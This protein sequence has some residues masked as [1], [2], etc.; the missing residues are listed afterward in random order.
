MARQRR[1]GVAGGGRHSAVGALGAPTSLRCSETRPADNSLHSLRSL[2]SD[3]IRE[4]V[5]EAR[6]YAR[7]RASCAARRLITAA[8]GH[9]HAP[10]LHCRWWSKGTPRAVVE[11]QAV[12]GAIAVRGG[13]EPGHKQS[14]GL[15]VPGERP[16]HWPGLERRA[17]GGACTHALQHLT[18][19]CCLSVTSEASEASDPR[20]LGPSTAAEWAP[21][22]PTADSGERTGHRLSRSRRSA[23]LV[24]NAGALRKR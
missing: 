9:P 7:G 6:E 18:R 15:F 23:R 24:R 8:A 3:N 16:G 14:S 11:R 19:G 2:R 12:P 20:A 1:V 22:A 4:S 13:S 17:K 21:Q 10:L 5:F